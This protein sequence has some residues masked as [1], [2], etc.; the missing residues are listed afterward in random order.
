LGSDLNARRQTL[1]AAQKA[2]DLRSTAVHTGKLEASERN[3]TILNAAE[4]LCADIALR[5][6]TEGFPK[7][8]N[9]LILRD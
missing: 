5:L 1:K 4:R 9:D 2:Y 7:D 8:W 6:I 3:S